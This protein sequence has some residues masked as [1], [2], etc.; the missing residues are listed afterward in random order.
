MLILATAV[1][2]TIVTAIRLATVAGLASTVI[3][4]CDATAQQQ[5]SGNR[6]QVAGVSVTVRVQP[7]T[8]ARMRPELQRLVSGALERYRSI[9]GGPF[10]SARGTPLDS[11]QVT[12]TAADGS[13]NADPG[14][15][16]IFFR[17][18]PFL[19]FYDWRLAMLHES[20]H[21]WNAESFRYSGSGEQWFNEGACEFYMLQTAVRL[22]VLNYL[23]AIRNMG[24]A[25]GFYA[26]ASGADVS[27]AD[28]GMR[29]GPNY[30]L[31]YHGGWT[32]ALL[33]DREIRA[34]SG[35]TKSLDDLMR[36]LYTNFPRGQRLYTNADLVRGIQTSTGVDVADF[37]AR[38]IQGTE[39]LP[40]GT[41]QLGDLSRILLGRAVGMDVPA[42]DT[43]LM[44]SLGIA[45]RRAQP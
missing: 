26:S 15:V 31:V 17:P 35:N 12:L 25:V 41:L 30:F 38:H 39:R 37:F 6:F 34:R 27:L 3:A 33:L 1:R 42:P 23:D 11:L 13:S 20:C 4:A 36:W 18:Q 29:K 44:A 16:Q 40:V 14:I 10:R 43:L 19:G 2:R 8:L 21:L 9:F 7:D 32:A 22:G 28:A 24:S 45:S 5:P